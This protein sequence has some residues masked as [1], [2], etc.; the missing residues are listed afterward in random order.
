MFDLEE[1]F[2]SGKSDSTLW[3]ITELCGTLFETENPY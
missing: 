2:G 1:I 3:K